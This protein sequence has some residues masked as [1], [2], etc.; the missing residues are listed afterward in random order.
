M[1]N[2]IRL[3]FERHTGES[4]TAWRGVHMDQNPEQR[5]ETRNFSNAFIFKLAVKTLV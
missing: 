4:K 2:I 1:Q 5:Q 3:K